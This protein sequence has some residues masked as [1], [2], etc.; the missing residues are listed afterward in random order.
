M[1]PLEAH[2]LILKLVAARRWRIVDDALP[3]GRLGIGRVDAIARTTIMGFPAD[4]TIRIKAAGQQSRI[5]IRSVSRTPWHE[6]ASNAERIQALA[7]DLD[8]QSDDQ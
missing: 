4:V 5:D 3:L 8:D 2:R 1:E 7:S 6:P